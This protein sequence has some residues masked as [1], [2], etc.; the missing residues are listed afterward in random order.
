MALRTGDQMPATT[1]LPSSARLIASIRATLSEINETE[2]LSEAAKLRVSAA[3]EALNELL[4]REDIGFFRTYFSDC[5]DLLDRGVA[6]LASSDLGLCA[7]DISRLPRRITQEAG[8]ASASLLIAAALSSLAQLVAIAVGRSDQASSRFID[9]VVQLEHR[10]HAHRRVPSMTLEAL[11]AS[12]RAAV[13]ADKFLRYLQ[14]K[15]PEDTITLSRFEELVGGFQKTTILFSLDREGARSESLVMRLEKLHEKFVDL[16]AGTVAIE[17]DVVQF[18]HERGIPSASPKWLEADARFMGAPF[19]VTSHVAGKSVKVTGVDPDLL[20]PAE[21][22]TDATLRSVVETLAQIHALPT[23]DLADTPIGHGLRHASLAE[24]T[25]ELVK[26]WST[27]RWSAEMGQSPTV[28]LALNW[29]RHNI[30]TDEDSLALVHVDYGLHNILI[31]GERVSAVLDWESARVGDPAED[32]AYLMQSLG[33]AAKRDQI[34]GWYEAASGKKI[35]NQRLRYFDVYNAFKV[36]VA[37]CHAAALFEHD[38]RTGIEWCSLG[39]FIFLYGAAPLQDKIAAAE[40]A[41]D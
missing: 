20:P 34:I 16:P 7:I 32:L 8:F 11:A 21:R 28:E 19:M 15:F 13:S 6:L 23:H 24:N 14:S 35:S 18:I 40:A 17:F 3:S 31:D 30:P 37:G 22:L 27:Q 25:R 9:E 41:S 33:P 1:I 4:L 12:R 38:R 10:F 29:L 26:S 39:L 5:R 36:L 2:P